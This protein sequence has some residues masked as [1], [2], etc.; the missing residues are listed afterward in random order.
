MKRLLSVPSVCFLVI[1]MYGTAV[2]K[3][4]SQLRKVVDECKDELNLPKDLTLPEMIE[5]HEDQMGCYAGCLLR[6]QKVIVDGK[7]IIEEFEKKTLS[8]AEQE[9]KDKYIECV[10][11]AN[12]ETGE[13]EIATA[14][15]ECINKNY[16]LFA[17][18]LKVFD[19]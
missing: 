10:D 4:D 2:A 9:V 17:K 15:F 8:S 19:H 16:E 1:C 13:C 11:T 14:F 18:I 6:K 12:K 5:K 3:H 7:F